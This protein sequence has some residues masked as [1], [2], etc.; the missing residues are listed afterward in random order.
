MPNQRSSTL[1][2]L[3]EDVLG[4]KP[5]ADVLRK[6]LVLGG[7]LGSTE[8]R[9]WA[10][11]QL[12]GYG[13]DDDVPDYRTVA[14]PIYLDGMVG[15]GMITRQRISPLS[16][17]ELVHEHVRETYTLRSGVGEI[18]ALIAQAQ[19]KGGYVNLSIPSAADLGRL[20]DQQSGN[21]YQH[22]DSLYWSISEVALRNIADQIRTTLAELVAELR[23]VMPRGH[24]LPDPVDAAQAVQ[25]AVHGNR[26]RIVMRAAH[27]TAGSV[28]T[29]DD[30]EA[31]HE[32]WWTRGRKIGAAVVGFFT[33]A[34]AVAAIVAVVR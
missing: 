1:N 18:E 21:P 25:V 14:A 27:A 9:D 7:E 16:L 28:A 2:D 19:T 17:P 12:R 30:G 15:N 29:V 11:K 6:C 23:A 33:I 31:D 24:D 8:L 10:N 20:M 3:A 4:A 22:I 13:D 5:L 26:N 34:G 32:T